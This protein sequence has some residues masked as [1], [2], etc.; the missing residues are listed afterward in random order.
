M[1][2]SF[3]LL[4]SLM[5]SGAP[6]HASE[7]STLCVYSREGR[8]GDT[9]E[10]P[11]I[12][13]WDPAMRGAF[14]IDKTTGTVYGRGRPPFLADTIGCISDIRFEE[15]ICTKSGKWVTGDVVK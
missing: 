10:F 5:L 8:P 2:R 4:S 12:V 11:C 7:L 9:R 15:Q 13:R 1:K 6:A 3:I 14:I